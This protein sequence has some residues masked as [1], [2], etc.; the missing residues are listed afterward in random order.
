MGIEYYVIDSDVR[1]NLSFKKIQCNTEKYIIVWYIATVVLCNIILYTLTSKNKYTYIL[2]IYTRVLNNITVHLRTKILRRRYNNR[3][4]TSTFYT[5]NK[6]IPKLLLFLI[7]FYF[8]R[9]CHYRYFYFY[10]Y[11]RRH[12]MFC[13]ARG[14]LMP[15]YRPLLYE[16][17]TRRFYYTLLNRPAHI[18]A[19]H[20]TYIILV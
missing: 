17:R 14:L 12:R 1:G 18:Y 11:D 4:K 16:I 19:M 7:S 2:Y 6:Y 3:D 10:F 13:D 5:V 20:F 9:Y 15:G 8:Y